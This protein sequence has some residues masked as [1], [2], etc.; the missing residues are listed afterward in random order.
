MR[1]GKD[2]VVFTKQQ[3]SRSVGLLSQTY[4]EEIKAQTILV[5]I[6]S[7]NSNG[8]I[9]LN[10]LPLDIYNSAISAVLSIS[11]QTV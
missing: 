1:L 3:D 10:E 5:P 7:W 4:L 9:L 8:D 2:A 6:V 11:R